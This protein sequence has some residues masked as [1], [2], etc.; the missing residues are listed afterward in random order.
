MKQ[1]RAFGQ[2]DESYHAKRI[3]RSLA[4]AGLL[5]HESL[6]YAYNVIS[7]VMNVCQ[8]CK[9]CLVPKNDAIYCDSVECGS[10]AAEEEEP[11]NERH[12]Y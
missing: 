10:R 4:D 1:P 6:D 8:Y 3:A 9:A 2:G 7:A 12:G 11:E 5:A